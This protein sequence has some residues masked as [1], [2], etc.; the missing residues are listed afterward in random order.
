MIISRT[1]EMISLYNPVSSEQGI[2]FGEELAEI[3][4]N[5]PR[6]LAVKAGTEEPKECGVCDYCVAKKKLSKLVYW[7]NIGY[8]MVG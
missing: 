7:Q 3:E 4:R 6:I 2:I 1:K 5:M 8:N